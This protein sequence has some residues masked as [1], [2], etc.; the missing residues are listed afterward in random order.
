[1][2]DHPHERALEK[3]DLVRRLPFVLLSALLTKVQERCKNC[4]HHVTRLSSPRYQGPK[5][6]YTLLLE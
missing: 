5:R 1:M 6:L 3:V 2:G 4:V